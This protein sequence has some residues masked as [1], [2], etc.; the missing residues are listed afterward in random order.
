[1]PS[2]PFVWVLFLWPYYFG[3]NTLE[4]LGTM[5]LFPWPSKSLFARI[6]CFFS[7]LLC[8]G[9]RSDK[10]EKKCHFCK[11]HY[12]SGTVNSKS[13]VGKVLLQIKWKLELN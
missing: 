13:F 11:T 5:D 2:H 6:N 7:D 4:V 1:M 3:K 12:R 8:I 9:K 10:F